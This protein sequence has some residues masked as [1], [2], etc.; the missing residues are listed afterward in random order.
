MKTIFSLYSILL[1]IIILNKI[2]FSQESN[3]IL[4]PTI[5]CL[6]QLN[7]KNEKEM[8]N[9]KKCISDFINERKTITKN[10][11]KIRILDGSKKLS[12]KV[13]N[14]FKK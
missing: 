4:K 10:K 1:L 5:S 7:P 14:S 12:E 2:C 8:E 6:E 9:F 11:Y 3:L 13:S